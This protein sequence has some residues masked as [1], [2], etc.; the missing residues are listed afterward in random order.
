V[1]QPRSAEPRLESRAGAGEPGLGV[2]G[3]GLH[4]ALER[5]EGVPAG[6]EGADLLGAVELDRGHRAAF[7]IGDQRQVVELEP[8]QSS[9]IQSARSRLSITNRNG[10]NGRGHSAAKC[11]DIHISSTSACD[12]PSPEST[13][14]G[15]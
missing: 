3:R 8:G 4:P 2:G 11:T 15:L 6:I 10:R 9:D 14:R 7:S 13:T 12:L 1:V 5:A